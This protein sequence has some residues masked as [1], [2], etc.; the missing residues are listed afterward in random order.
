MQAWMP[1][2]TPWSAYFYLTILNEIPNFSLSQWKQ[3]PSQE[4]IVAYRK[5]KAI[6]LDI[7]GRYR[8]L[9]EILF[10]SDLKV[11][12]LLPCLLHF[13]RI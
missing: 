2:D 9:S 13:L 8:Y 6:A 3:E 7:L 11:Q 4:S 12:K 1:T 10:I 5:G